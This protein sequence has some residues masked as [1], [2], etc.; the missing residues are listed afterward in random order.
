MIGYFVI[1]QYVP[2]GEWVNAA[3]RREV[4]KIID[5]FDEMAR[6]ECLT[7]LI[8]LNP[9]E[10]PFNS[11]CLLCCATRLCYRMDRLLHGPAGEGDIVKVNFKTAN[12]PSGIVAGIVEQYWTIKDSEVS[13]SELF[14]K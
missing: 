1:F 5:A 7:R 14:N 11:D 12:V 9:E 2:T 4:A 8:E 10:P 13:V 6:L 3:H